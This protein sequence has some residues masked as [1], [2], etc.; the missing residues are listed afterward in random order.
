MLRDVLAKAPTRATDVEAK[1]VHYSGF[2]RRLGCACHTWA[3]SRS[4]RAAEQD[5]PHARLTGPETTIAKIEPERL[6]SGELQAECFR[7]GNCDQRKFQQA[8]PYYFAT[9]PERIYAGIPFAVECR[10][11]AAL[12]KCGSEITSSAE[13]AR[14]WF[15]AAPWPSILARFQP[16]DPSEAC[17]E[18]VGVTANH[19][20]AF[21]RRHGES[22]S[23]RRRPP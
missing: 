15:H 3:V 8:R 18:P 14:P 4:G 16:F 13:S 7:D 5:L 6:G 12:R 17:T 1:R 22:S 23:R 9:L 19:I 2:I 20:D 11:S 10:E 21:P